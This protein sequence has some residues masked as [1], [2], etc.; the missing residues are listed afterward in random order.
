MLHFSFNS[1]SLFLLLPRSLLLSFSAIFFNSLCKNISSASNISFGLSFA[2][3][4]RRCFLKASLS[5]MKSTIDSRP[6]QN[7]CTLSFWLCFIF[8]FYR[9][10]GRNLMVSCH[11]GSSRKRGGDH[12]LPIFGRISRAWAFRILPCTH[13]HIS[14]GKKIIFYFYDNIIVEIR[15]KS[16]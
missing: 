3:W 16:Q 14:F 10:T 15:T 13:P 9:L 12:G 8:L 4:H 7:A 11:V 2:D 5:L 6:S 1:F